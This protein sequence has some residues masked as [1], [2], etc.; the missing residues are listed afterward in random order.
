MAFD[1][2][3]MKWFS[4]TLCSYSI[5]A[6]EER[7]G[8]EMLLVVLHSNDKC[9]LQWLDWGV[10]RYGYD[11]KA[12][13]GQYDSLYKQSKI[14]PFLLAK[15]QQEGLG[16]E[17]V[18]GTIMIGNTYQV[19]FEIFQVTQSVQIVCRARMAQPQE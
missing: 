13:W 15:L 12:M 1:F 10:Q 7:L 17:F 2:F 4:T 6:D 5:L 14:S 9:K 19:E 18:K 16:P 11:S 3:L 8:S